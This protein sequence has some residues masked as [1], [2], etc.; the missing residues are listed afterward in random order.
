MTSSMCR[1]RH[2]ERSHRTSTIGAA[3]LSE[4]CRFV[5]GDAFESV[6]AGGDAYLLSNFVISWGDEE[7]LVPLRNCRKAMAATG[8]LLLV[9]WI[10]PTGEASTDS[11]RFWDSVTMDLI[12]LA[13]F[14]SGGGHVRTLP[15]FETLLAAAG[16][17]VTTALPTRAS[18]W[19]IEAVPV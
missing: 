6:P 13:A 2:P 19:V 4:R 18:V 5:G 9:E 14:G 3:A 10:M 12:M 16:F 1:R 11:F 15:E 8:K 7:A 17:R